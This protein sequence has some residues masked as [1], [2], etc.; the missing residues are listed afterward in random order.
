MIHFIYSL[1]D[2]QKYISTTECITISGYEDH[3]N[4]DVQPSHAI[5]K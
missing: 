3:K 1:E 4:D 5:C 2:V